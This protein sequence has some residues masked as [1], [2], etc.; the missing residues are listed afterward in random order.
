M[1]RFGTEELWLC[2]VSIQ[3]ETIWNLVCRKAMVD[4]VLNILGGGFKAFLFSS[5]FGKMNLF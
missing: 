3:M 2:F 1:K 5:L 4:N